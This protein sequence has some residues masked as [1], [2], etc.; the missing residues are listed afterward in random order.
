MQPR[1]RQVPPYRASFSI[2]AVFKPSWPARIAATYPPGPVPMI[3][4]S[5]GACSFT[6]A[7]LEDI[8]MFFVQQRVRLHDD[9]LLRPVFEFI[10]RDEFPALQNLGNLGVNAHRD[11]F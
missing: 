1:R 6:S 8:E 7:P 10:Q 2:T 5:N 9:V 3:A 4:T 11:L